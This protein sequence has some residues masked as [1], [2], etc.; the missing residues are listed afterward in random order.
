LL[1]PLFESDKKEKI[2]FY[3]Y[4]HGEGYA[5]EIARTF[6]FNL[7]TVQNQLRNLEGYGV[8][9]SRIKGNVR[10]YCFN[11]RYPFRDEL[12][13]LLK[14]AM[15]YL[16][17]DEVRK[18]YWPHV[19]PKRA[20]SSVQERTQK[21]ESSTQEHTL[22]TNSS[23]QKNTLKEGI[24]FALSNPWEKS[25]LDRFMPSQASSKGKSRPGIDGLKDR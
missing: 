15:M 2:L 5:R 16:S 19:Q 23:T 22:R 6:R 1:E 12:L 24:S 17:E 21:A 13:E 18:Y 10:I 8:L 20:D 25:R 14:K 3:L 4:S 9:Y 11:P 7:N